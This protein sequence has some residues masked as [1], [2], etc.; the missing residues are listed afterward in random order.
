VKVYRHPL[1]VGGGW[2]E[3]RLSGPV[4]HIACRAGDPDT[5]HVWALEDAGT[6]YTARLGVFGTGHPVPDE[7]VYR[8]TAISEPYVWHV[9]EQVT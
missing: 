4:V 7:S 1:K 8:G 9:F 3:V 5:V 6:P 2:Q